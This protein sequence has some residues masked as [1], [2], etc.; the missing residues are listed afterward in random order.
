MSVL[1]TI[2]WHK[3]VD[4]IFFPQIKSFEV[5]AETKVSKLIPHLIL[6]MLKESLN[7]FGAIERSWETNRPRS[8]FPNLRIQSMNV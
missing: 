8:N 3:P 2:Y 1:T 6:L 5:I 4:L 7:A